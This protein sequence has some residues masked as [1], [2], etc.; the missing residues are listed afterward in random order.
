MNSVGDIAGNTR[1][2]DSTIGA[3][4]FFKLFPKTHRKRIMFKARK[5]IQVSGHTHFEHI[6]FFRVTRRYS[7]LK[8]F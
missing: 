8:L 2:L 3:T 5:R 7:D 1:V 4:L 6:L